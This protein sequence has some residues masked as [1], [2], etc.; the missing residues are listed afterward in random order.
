MTITIEELIVADPP[1]AWAHLGFHVHEALC[2]V[3]SVG[4]RLA[5][6]DA[7]RGITGW[8]LR[9]LPEGTTSLD[10]I[11][12]TASHSAPRPPAEHSNGVIAIDH[13]VVLSPNLA[14]TVETLAAVGARP[15]RERDGV[16]G[17]QPI[18]QVF[19]R[20]GEVI[21]EVVGSPETVDEGP[22]T[23]WG[24]TYTVADIDAAAARFGDLTTPVK[25]AV[26]PG[27]RITTLRH[28]ELGISVRTA[29][30]SPPPPR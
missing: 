26:Q 9:E 7:G 3:G 28:R 14:R 15:R 13:V 29:L 24:I 27:R 25:D 21:L 12:T 20:F 16:L 11:P 19:F 30:I 6:G 18:R 5:G 8:S 10:G 22:A 17:G 23:L 1:E 4:I 2:Q